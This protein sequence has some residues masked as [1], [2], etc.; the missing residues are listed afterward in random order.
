[1]WKPIN[2]PLV[3]LDQGLEMG[4]KSCREYNDLK[5]ISHKSL[6]SYKF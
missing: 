6:L 2:V 1:M 3:D 5:S 4:L